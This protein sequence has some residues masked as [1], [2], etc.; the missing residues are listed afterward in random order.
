[1]SMSRKISW[2]MEEK[3]LLNV[4]CRTDSTDDEEPQEGC[5]ESRWLDEGEPCKYKTEMCKNYSEMGFCHY[6]EKCQFAHGYHDLALS[7]ERMTLHLGRSYRTKR[8][9]NF[10]SRGECLYGLRCQFSHHEVSRD[11]LNTL[12]ILRAV[13]DNTDAPLVVGCR[14]RL[15]QGLYSHSNDIFNLAD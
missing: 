2:A 9:K 3:E 8:C 12:K 5:E 14:S 6:Y 15:I 13:V 7:P 11:T 4:S 1:M 10:W